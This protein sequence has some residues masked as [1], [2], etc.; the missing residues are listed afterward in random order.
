MLWKEREFQRWLDVRGQELKRLRR[1]CLYQ[2]PSGRNTEVNRKDASVRTTLAYGCIYEWCYWNGI[3]MCL[4]PTFVCEHAVNVKTHT[5]LYIRH[6][7]TF[8]QRVAA[9][10][11]LCCVILV[12]HCHS[13]YWCVICVQLQCCR[14]C[15]LPS[16][17]VTMMLKRT[18]LFVLCL[19]N[20][21]VKS[22]E[23]WSCLHMA[24]WYS[25]NVF[26][27][28]AFPFGIQEKG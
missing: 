10:G 20:L 27:A 26:P 2:C 22:V 12:N 21:V 13:K 14:V 17:E 5:A 24:S 1:F 28:S 9:H 8:R 15:S 16:D 7:V 11:S 3:C 6:R 4:F 25:W 23:V 18:K 19:F